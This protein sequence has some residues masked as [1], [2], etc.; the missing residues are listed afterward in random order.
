MIGR[1]FR[2]YEVYDFDAFY[3]TTIL[4]WKHMRYPSEKTEICMDCVVIEATESFSNIA[5]RHQRLEHVS[6]SFI[7]CRFLASGS[8]ILAPAFFFADTNAGLQRSTILGALFHPFV[9]FAPGFE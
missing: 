3:V 6:S 7:Y 9:E 8:G 2:L 5:R 4:S 1:L